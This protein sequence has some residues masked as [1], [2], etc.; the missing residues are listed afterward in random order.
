M[1]PSTSTLPGSRLVYSNVLDTFAPL[2]TDVS[3]TS[4]EKQVFSPIG[5]IEEDLPIDIVVGPTRQHYTSPYDSILM[6]TLKIVKADG[7][8]IAAADKVTLNSIPFH[9]LFSEVEVF[10]NGTATNTCTALNPY[11]GYLT[12]LLNYTPEQR[13]KELSAQLYFRNQKETLDETDPGFKERF[14]YTTLSRVVQLSGRLPDA[15]FA[16]N[17]WIPPGV[18]IHLRLKKNETRFILEGAGLTSP[19]AYKIKLENISFIVQRYLP[20]PDI[21][22]L[23]NNLF[24][25]NRKMNFPLSLVSIKTFPVQENTN[26][27]ISSNLFAGNLPKSLFVGV[28]PLESFQGKEATDPFLF[29]RQNVKMMKVIVD[30]ENI[31]SRQI[32]IDSDDKSLDAYYNLINSQPDRSQGLGLS[33]KEFINSNFLL[34]FNLNESKSAARFSANKYGSLKVRQIIPIVPKHIKDDDF[35]IFYS[36]Y[37]LN[38]SSQLQTQRLCVSSSLEFLTLSTLSISTRILKPREE[39]R[40]QWILFRCT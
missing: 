26:G 11:R 3:F 20:H 34:Y 14:D 22:S 38:S 18:E 1:D 10:L 16:E 13:A 25:Q 8:N 6:A 17:R 4:S 27:V 5:N 33:R 31:S 24:A 15:V 19:L 28:L 7:T 2:T 9:S 12:N 32:V 29:K 23:H 35:N 30:G 40:K 21:V 39:L 36:Y 37:R